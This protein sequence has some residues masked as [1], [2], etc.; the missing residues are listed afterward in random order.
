MSE[1]LFNIVFYGIIQPDKD[2][3]T[4]VQN[5]AS[6]FKTDPARLAPYFAGGRK[7]IKSNID[8]LVAEKYRATLEDIGLV[9]K[10][11]NAEP[12][13]ETGGKSEAPP[14]QQPAQTRGE[15][16]AEPL[17]QSQ[18]TRPEQVE[19]GGISMAEVGA[20]IIETPAEVTPQA[21]EDI[22]DISMAEVGADV[23]ENPAEVTPQAI[24]D[25][26]DISMAEVG[27][28]VI[29]NPVEVTP[30]AIEDISDISMAEVGV[31]IVENPKEKEKTPEPDISGLS[32]E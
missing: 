12:A 11:E 10:I 3:D 16:T 27:A 15:S 18:T 17:A 21:I 19:T 6:L 28:D 24:E 1:P 5:M 26:S 23:I 32:L 22:S 4:V 30:Q 2:K 29:E 31:D 7:V 20:D 13:V 14:R 8:K 9:I 25:I